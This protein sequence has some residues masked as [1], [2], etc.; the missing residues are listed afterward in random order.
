M[1]YKIMISL[2]ISAVIFFVI[3]LELILSQ[4]VKKL[5]PK[6][7]LDFEG[8]MAAGLFSQPSNAEGFS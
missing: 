4:P 5:A 2:S 7:G 8:V 3:A 1:I 6:A